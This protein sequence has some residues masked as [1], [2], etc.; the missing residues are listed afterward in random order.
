MTQYLQ[1]PLRMI[2]TNTTQNERSVLTNTTQKWSV[3]NTTQNDQY[4]GK[5][6]SEWRQ[7][8]KYHSE[9]MISTY[10]Y[11]SEWSVLQIPPNDQYYNSSLRMIRTTNT[12]QNDQYFT[13]TH[14]EWL[15]YLANTTQWSVLIIGFHSESSVL[16]NTFQNT[17]TNTTQNHQY[18]QIPLRMTATNSTRI[19][20]TYK[21]HSEW[22]SY[23]YHS[24]DQYLQ[25]PPEWPFTNTTQ[26]DQHLQIPLRMN[27]QYLTNT[28]SEWDHTYKY[29]SEW[30][31]LMSLTCESSVLIN[32]TQNHQYYKYH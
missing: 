2:T 11:H 7:Y 10:K 12:T 1:I 17:C 20:S 29:H 32:T 18:L 26:N 6:H 23:K 13:N 3:P 16:T 19:I 14:S 28:T 4:L 8:H 25:I 31:V 5:Y 27:D 30:S 21:Y 22:S 24:D 15:G 9:W